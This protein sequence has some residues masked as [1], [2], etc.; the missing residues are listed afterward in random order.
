MSGAIL[1]N[2]RATRPFGLAGGAPGA[3]GVTRL[4]RANGETIELAAADRFEARPGDVIEVLTPG[5][6]GFGAPDV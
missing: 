2:R 3:A 4:R 1:A 5:G 6:G